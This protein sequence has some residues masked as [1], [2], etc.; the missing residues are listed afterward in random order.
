[1]CVPD[2]STNLDNIKAYEGAGV[3]VTAK[4]D[5]SDC[6]VAMQQGEA[7]AITGD[8][9]V[10]AGFAA[11]DPTTEVVGE[12]FSDEPYGLGMSAGAVDFVR[13]VNAV[14]EEV[15]RDGRWSASYQR[16]LIDSGALN[17][18]VPAAPPP[19]YGREAG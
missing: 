17:G 3:I 4:P 12:R 1:M 10:L 14:L 7:D 15:R 9:T 6:L 19:L 5:I 18:P 8:D 13:F 2:G 16:W 11:Q